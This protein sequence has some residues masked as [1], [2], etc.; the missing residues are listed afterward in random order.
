MAEVDFDLSQAAD[1]MKTTRLGRNKLH[2]LEEDGDDWQ[3]RFVGDVIDARLAGTDANTIAA[4][5]FGKNH[6]VKFAGGAA[7]VLKFANASGIEFAAFEEEP[8]PTAKNPFNPG[9]MPDGFVA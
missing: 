6:E 9:G 1:Q 3:A 8:D 2:V 7:K 5:A 4:S